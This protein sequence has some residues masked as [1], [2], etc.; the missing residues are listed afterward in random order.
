MS[1][2][3]DATS[4]LAQLE[5]GTTKTHE[6][7]SSDI[8]KTHSVVGYWLPHLRRGF[9]GGLHQFEYPSVNGV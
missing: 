4:R 3:K 8:P 1:R 2:W 7:D 9:T 6:D 5:E